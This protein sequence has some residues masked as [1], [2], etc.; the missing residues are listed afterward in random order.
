MIAEKEKKRNKQTLMS[1]L[2]PGK[3]T[4]KAE[5]VFRALGSAHFLLSSLPVPSASE[6]Q[7]AFLPLSLLANPAITL[8]RAQ[9]QRALDSVS[10]WI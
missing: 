7:P 6:Y 8:C 1:E 2:T 4:K 10:S 9:G 3:T 5:N